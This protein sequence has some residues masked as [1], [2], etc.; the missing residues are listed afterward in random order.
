MAHGNQDRQFPI[1]EMLAAVAAILGVVSSVFFYFDA[2]Q[3][4][5]N[6]IV[7]ALAERYESVDREMSYEQALEAVDKNFAILKDEYSKLQTLNDDL[8]KENKLLREENNQLKLE[9]NEIQAPDTSGNR[10][11]AM[12]PQ[13]VA[14]T[15]QTLPT[16]DQPS[17]GNEAGV[18]KISINPDI[19]IHENYYYEYPDPNNP[20]SN[21][22]INFGKG[23]SGTFLYSRELTAQERID[24]LDGGKLYDNDGN[25]IGQEG[26]WPTFCSEPD[27]KFAVEFPQN[28]PAGHYT[29]ELY[30]TVSGQSV[31]DKIGFDIS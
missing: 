15:E 5:E 26:N 17:N 10:V 14:P 9:G 4:T 2:K 21:I 29:Y 12:K 22:V 30:Q 18:L 24:W 19:Q 3:S 20:S 25:E 31:S 13:D 16:V 11:P 8:Q 1:W 27:G 28:L 6:K 7:E 23:I